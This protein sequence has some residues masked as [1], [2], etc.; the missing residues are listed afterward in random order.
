MVE[1]CRTLNGNDQAA[2]KGEIFLGNDPDRAMVEISLVNQS[3]L[4]A[5]RYR[6]QTQETETTIKQALAEELITVLDES[7]SNIINVHL[8]Y[9]P[10]TLLKPPLGPCGPITPPVTHKGNNYYFL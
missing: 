10:A 4:L 1:Y 6:E 7:I 8:R 5:R 2:T 3:S 9:D